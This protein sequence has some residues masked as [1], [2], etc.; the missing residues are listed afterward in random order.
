MSSLL[1]SNTSA[2]AVR[3]PCSINGR[4]ST[5]A[6]QAHN[7]GRVAAQDVFNLVL[8][9]VHGPDA[10]DE[11]LHLVLAAD[12]LRIVRAEQNIREWDVEQRGFDGGDLAEMAAGVK[13]HPAEIRVEVMLGLLAVDG[14]VQQAPELLVLVVA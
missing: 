14:V 13:V 9:E 4:H 10:V 11:G 2:M 1:R 7:P 12:L 6:S 3:L 5:P 8:G